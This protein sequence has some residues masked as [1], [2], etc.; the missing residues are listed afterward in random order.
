MLKFTTTTTSIYPP[1]NL[2]REL[3]RLFK[4]ND[5]CV[6]CSQILEVSTLLRHPL[7]SNSTLLNQRSLTC[8]D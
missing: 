7:L 6:P 4:S 2:S 1:N 8:L 5:K 3:N